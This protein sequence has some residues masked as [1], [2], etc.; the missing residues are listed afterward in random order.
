MQ[1]REYND[2]SML[3]DRK[4]LC[5]EIWNNCFDNYLSR[6]LPPLSRSQHPRWSGW[7]AVWQTAAESHVLADDGWWWL[8][9]QLCQQGVDL[10]QQVACEDGRIAGVF[11]YGRRPRSQFERVYRINSEHVDRICLWTC[12]LK[13]HPAPYNLQNVYIWLLCN[14]KAGKEGP[15][16]RQGS[17][18]G[19]WEDHQSEHG[20]NLEWIQVRAAYLETCGEKYNLLHQS[21]GL[22]MPRLLI[23]LIHVLSQVHPAIVPHHPPSLEASG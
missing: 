13:H 4:L 18:C 12:L 23:V 3:V 5:Q 10:S 21:C 8:T 6:I 17:S 2:M 20:R 1:T 19:F 16:H 22:S 14:T 9:Q 15:G 11:E 7:G